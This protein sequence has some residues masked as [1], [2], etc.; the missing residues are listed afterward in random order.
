MDEVEVDYERLAAEVSNVFAA[1]DALGEA[2]DA[3]LAA[4]EMS[5]NAFGMLCVMMVPPSQ[6][7]Q[8]VAV[9]ALKAEAAAYEAAA[10]NLRNTAADYETTDMISAMAHL[11]LA[12][13]IR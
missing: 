10:M 4:Q 9:S 13:R 11:A 6:L 7:V 2:V 5:Q 3:G 8:H 12:R 1:S